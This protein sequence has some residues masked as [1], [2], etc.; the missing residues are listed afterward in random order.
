MATL[1]EESATSKKGQAATESGQM[2]WGTHIETHMWKTRPQ[3]ILEKRQSEGEIIDRLDP[4]TRQKATPLDTPMLT[5]IEEAMVLDNDV[6][7]KEGKAN[8]RQDKTIK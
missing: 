6:D 8:Q 7:Y 4:K 2:S 1:P 3:P 5:A